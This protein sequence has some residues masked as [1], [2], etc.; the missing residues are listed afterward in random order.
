M[1][2]LKSDSKHCLYFHINMDEQEVFYVG[3]GNYKRPY[4][5]YKKSR[6]EEWFEVTEK[7]K[8]SIN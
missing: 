7:Y 5:T 1:E 6:S 4:M 3:I 8:I 2:E